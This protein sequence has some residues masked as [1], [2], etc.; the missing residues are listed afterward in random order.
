MQLVLSA[1][2][3]LVFQTCGLPGTA[4]PGFHMPPLR[5]WDE[6]V[7][8]ATAIGLI[9]QTNSINKKSLQ[10]S[11]AAP[12]YANLWIEASALYNYLRE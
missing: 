2:A 12:G 11:S 9:A 8:P 7:T 4:V 5:G 6:F 3:D 1:E 10:T